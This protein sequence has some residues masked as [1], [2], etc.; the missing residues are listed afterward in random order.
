MHGRKQE[1]RRVMSF[2][3]CVPCEFVFSLKGQW[4]V[5]VDLFEVFQREECSIGK[6]KQMSSH[7]VLIYYG[8]MDS[9]T[10]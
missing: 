8:D 3:C 4:V 9:I 1:G 6:R 5:L 10:T 7:F 2:L